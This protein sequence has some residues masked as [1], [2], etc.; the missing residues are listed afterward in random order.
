MEL[1]VLEDPCTDYVSLSSSEHLNELD[2]LFIYSLLAA[3]LYWKECIP[4]SILMSKERWISSSIPVL[5]FSANTKRKTGTHL[6][7]DIQ[8]ESC[9]ISAGCLDS[10]DSGGLGCLFR[11]VLTLSDTFRY[12]TIQTFERNPLAILPSK[13]HATFWK[14]SDL[15]SFCK[16][17]FTDVATSTEMLTKC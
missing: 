1:C 17:R 14:W 2:S 15:Y 4:I 5:A 11:T 10:Q 13:V 6:Q 16:C 8:T 7:T 9:E 3:S 12:T